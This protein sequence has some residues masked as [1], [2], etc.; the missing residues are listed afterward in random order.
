MVQFEVMNKIQ[1]NTV[2]KKLKLELTLF[3]TFKTAK[4]NM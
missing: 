1:K 3:S 4:N 2:A